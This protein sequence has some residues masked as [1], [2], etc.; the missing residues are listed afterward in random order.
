[1][2]KQPE[3]L[4]RLHEV[5][6]E[7]LKRIIEADDSGELSQEEIEAALAQPPLPVQEPLT[8][9]R[10]D[11]IAHNTDPGDWNSL[12]CRDAW[13]LGFGKGFREAEKEHEIKGNH[14]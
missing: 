12:Y 13:H 10:V 9:E 2:N 3:A 7:L 4:R 1:M 6:A 5:N 14:K 11:Q 8:E